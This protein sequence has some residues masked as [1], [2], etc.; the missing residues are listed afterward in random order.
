M[1]SETPSSLSVSTAHGPSMAEE[2]VIKVQVEHH[3][4]PKSEQFIKEVTYE[5]IDQLT[6]EMKEFSRTYAAQQN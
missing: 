3:L 5:V 2:K 6:Q 4:S 1:R